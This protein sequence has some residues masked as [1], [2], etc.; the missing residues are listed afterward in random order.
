MLHHVGTSGFA[1]LR[2]RKAEYTDTALSAWAK[3]IAAQSWTECFTFFK[4]EKT[5]ATA[6]GTRR[7]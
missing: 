1:Y 2:R 7:S 4:H 5:P 3:Q 6:R